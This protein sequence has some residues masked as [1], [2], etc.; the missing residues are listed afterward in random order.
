MADS[1]SIE[2]IL[3]SFNI[4]PR[5]QPVRI[6]GFG[7][8]GIVIEA[9]DSVRNEAVSVKKL[10]K[11]EDIID[12]KRNLREIRSLRCLR[13]QS[14]LKLEN[15]IVH[16]TEGHDIGELYLVTPLMQSDLH[17]ILKSDQ[18]LT[19]EHAKYF[20]YQLLCALKYLHSANIVHR[21]IKPSNILINTDCSI[22]LCD[23]G[24]S[25]SITS[26][27]EDLTEYVVTRFYRAPEIMLSSHEYTKAVDVWSVGCTFGEILARR[28]LFPGSN[29]IKQI[30]LIIKALGK[31][32]DED[33]EFIVNPHARNF[34]STLEHR[35]SIPLQ[36]FIGRSTSQEALDLLAK[37]LEFSPKKRITVEE[38]LREPYLEEYH[39]SD[40][41]VEAEDP[42]DFSF[43]SEDHSFEYMK[44]LL[45]QELELCQ[46]ILADSTSA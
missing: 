32:K 33:L 25:R 38:A 30:D 43:E 41:E 45:K 7:A 44:Q 11:I 26:G 9:Y 3:A 21:D 28:V 34:V 42:I 31:P 5:Y 35:N 15:V 39:E 4:G 6:I 19:E 46:K 17:K 10:N 37:M 20:L 22:K 2:E 40:D 12:V 14:I 27:L 1:Q 29:Y 18:P 23:F 13:H 36:E 24:L 8:Y 16:E